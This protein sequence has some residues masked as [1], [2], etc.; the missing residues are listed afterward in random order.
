MGHG[1]VNSQKQASYWKAKLNSCVE[2]CTGCGAPMIEMPP[3]G[4]EKFE[5]TKGWDRK[6]GERILLPWIKCPNDHWY[7]V[8]RHTTPHAI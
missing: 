6:T 2:F 4:G 8:K 5:L 1:I 3:I 7:S